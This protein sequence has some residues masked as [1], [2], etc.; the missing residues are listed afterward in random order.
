MSGPAA[1]NCAETALEYIKRRKRE[2]ST[3]PPTSVLCQHTVI[4]GISANEAHI[5]IS[6]QAKI[7]PL[8]AAEIV[9][10]TTLSVT[11]FGVNKKVLKV[12][13][14]PTKIVFS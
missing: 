14:H 7:C 5:I 8:P 10:N 13:S 12:E 3:Q 2:I 11:K 6:L 4:K 9:K 1:P